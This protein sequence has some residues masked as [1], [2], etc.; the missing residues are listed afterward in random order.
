MSAPLITKQIKQNN[1]TDAQF[2]VLQRE[3]EKLKNNQNTPK[4]AVMFFD[5]VSCP[6]G[7]DDVSSSWNGRFIRIAG[8]YD[9]CDKTGVNNDGSCKK[10]VETVTNSVGTKQEDASRR[11]KG[12]FPAGET[13]IENLIDQEWDNFTDPYNKY[14]EQLRKYLVLEPPFDFWMKKDV[15]N[16]DFEYPENHTKIY[17]GDRPDWPAFGTKGDYVT[18][19][20]PA[21]LEFRG[22]HANREWFATTFDTKKVT[23]VASENRPRSLTLLACKKN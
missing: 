7:W 3:I 18:Y 15:T 9:I 5:L 22:A 20:D 11:I 13:Q 8:S 23:P 21:I 12:R 14:V 6:D 19:V 17:H 10:T 4:G 16:G 1:F 2:Q